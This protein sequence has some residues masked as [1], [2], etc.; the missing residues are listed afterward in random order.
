MLI[1]GGTFPTSTAC[2]VPEVYGFHNLDMGEDN[3]DLLQWDLFSPDKTIYKV[4]QEII[5]AVGGS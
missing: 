4:P 5:S 3:P 1:M 2:D